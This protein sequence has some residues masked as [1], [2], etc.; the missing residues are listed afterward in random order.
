MFQSYSTMTSLIVTGLGELAPG[1]KTY[2]AMVGTACILFLF[3]AIINLTVQAFTGKKKGQAR[4]KGKSRKKGA[5]YKT[6]FGKNIGITARPSERNGDY[7]NRGVLYKRGDKFVRTRRYRAFYPDKGIAASVQR[8]TVFDDGK[9]QRRTDDIAVYNFDADDFV[10]ESSDSR[11]HGTRRSDFSFGICEK[12]KFHHENHKVLHRNTCGNS[13]H[14]LR[15]FRQC[16]FRTRLR[17]RNKH[18]IGVAYNR[19]DGYS[20]YS[21]L[22]RGSDKIGAG[23]VQGH[24]KGAKL[25]SNDSRPKEH[26]KTRSVC[27]FFWWTKTFRNRSKMN[28]KNSLIKWKSPLFS[29]L[30][31]V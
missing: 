10:S 26:K 6:S 7:Q 31:Y 19:A 23:R 4:K 11:A 24:R 15:T 14:C 2:G 29:G 20:R 3:V 16:V 27:V 9:L 1:D 8:R 21:S 13:V 22:V 25:Q 12:R 17:A 18:I 28:L 30:F 5:R